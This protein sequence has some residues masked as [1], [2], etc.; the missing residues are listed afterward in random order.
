MDK[1]DR[2]LTGDRPASEDAT[3]LGQT[4]FASDVM[5]KNSLQ[6]EDQERVQNQRQAVPDVKLEP[7]ADPV[8]SAKMQDKDARAEAELNKGGGVHPGAAHPEADK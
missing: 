5:G 7:D 1:A 4:D 8:E 2:T 6:G 3:T